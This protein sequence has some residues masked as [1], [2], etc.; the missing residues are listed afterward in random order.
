TGST[1][2]RH[3]TRRV[4]IRR[5]IA[6]GRLRSVNAPL[7]DAWADEGA[8]GDVDI[9]RVIAVVPRERAVDRHV[10]PG[11][12]EEVI[13]HREH[14]VG[15]RTQRI[16]R[17]HVEDALLDPS[18]LVL[19]DLLAGGAAVRVVSGH[20]RGVPLELAYRRIVGRGVAAYVD[21][22]ALRLDVER[23]VGARRRREQALYVRL[24]L[25]D[26]TVGVVAGHRDAV[27]S[28]RSGLAGPAHVGSGQLVVLFGADHELGVRRRDAV[29]LEPIEEGREGGVVGLRVGHVAAVARANR[30]A[31][32]GGRGGSAVARTRLALVNIGDV[33]VGD[34]D[35]AFLH[36]SQVGEG[37]RRGRAEPGET[38][39]VAE[40]VGDR[41]AGQVGQDAVCVSDR[42]SVLRQIRR[43]RAEHRRD[44]S[45]AEQTL[46]A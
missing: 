19:H 29:L 25:A 32:S 15:R 46:V 42:V 20:R 7:C 13:R 37:L 8:P 28:G 17:L 22:R 4:R 23:R 11:G 26:L 45:G 39:G 6:A 18:G 43:T 41:S 35:A 44:I 1:G 27:T 38:G 21:R 9:R 3:R 24:Q 33:A 40:R 10:R 12:R 5:L 16:T 30:L 34:R 36:V 31:G 2:L 14:G